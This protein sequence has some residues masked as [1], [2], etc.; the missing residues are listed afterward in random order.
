MTS[1]H[2]LLQVFKLVIKYE[3]KQKLVMQ[4]LGVI[5][6]PPILEQPRS[7]IV[8]VNSKDYRRNRRNLLK[9]AKPEEKR[10][11]SREESAQELVRGTTNNVTTRSGRVSKP[12]LRYQA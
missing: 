11:K 4:V 2:V 10:R 12:V 1:Q 7:Y 5:K 9:V 6:R 3:L 8:T